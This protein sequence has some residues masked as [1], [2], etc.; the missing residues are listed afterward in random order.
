MT[1]RVRRHSQLRFF[2]FFFSLPEPGAED[3]N[4]SDAT[5]CKLMVP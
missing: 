5:G 4:L 2:F 3:R 1:R